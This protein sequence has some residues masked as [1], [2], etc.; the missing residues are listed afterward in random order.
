MELELA[1]LLLAGLIFALRVF[2]YS[3]STI[4]LVFIARGGKVIAA[5]IAF[6]EAL[7]FAIVMASVITEINNIP[8]LLAYCFGAAIGSYLGMWLEARFV[9]SYSTV[10]IITR[11]HAQ[12][13]ADTLREHNYG[14]TVTRGEGREGEVSLIHSST[15]NRS[16]PKLIAL[17]REINPD[18]FIQTEQ[19]RTVQR[20]WIPGGPP[21]RLRR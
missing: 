15:V 19:A 1:D 16:I 6:V 20:G 4:R 2:N 10:T 9:V 21:R 17:V 3:I 18:A 11:E 13:I 7:I 8:N 12:T 5:C 14:V